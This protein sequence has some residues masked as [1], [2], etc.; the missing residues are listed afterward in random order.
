MRPLTEQERDA[1]LDAC[2]LVE[3]MARDDALAKSVV[4]F[5]TDD[6]AYLRRVILTLAY[7][8]V[9]AAGDPEVLDAIRRCFARAPTTP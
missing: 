3:A 2:A 1:P 5:A 6:P 9:E 8:V 4:L 7:M